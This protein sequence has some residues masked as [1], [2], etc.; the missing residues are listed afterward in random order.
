[1]MSN[2]SIGRKSRSFAIGVLACLSMFAMLMNTL[3]AQTAGAGT[4]KG[5][6][7]D[8]SQ[9][10]VAGATV[11]VTN[12]D[13]GIAHQYTSNESGLYVA[14]FLQP[15]HYA[16][17]ATSTGFGKVSATNLT[18]QVG[19]TMTIDLSL[20]VQSGSTT[21]E[22]S[23]ETP[24]LNVEQT[25][26]SQV[27]DQ[28]IIQNLPV[29]GRNWSDFVLLTPNVVQDG[30]SGLVSFHGISGLYNQNYV[31]GANNN[32]M[33]FSEARGRSSGAPFVYSL[34]AIKEF[35]A[36][37]SNY[38]AEFGQAAGGQVNAI[39][40]NGT[41]DMH[42]DLF[43]ALR[44]PSFNALDPVS[45][46]SALFN[47]GNPFLLTQPVHQQ[48]GFGGSIGGPI[49][50][51]KLFYFLTSDNFRRTGR[52]LY[53][54]TNTV[55]QTPTGAFTATNVISPNQC[56]TT[57][58]SAQ[59]TSGINF[60]LGLQSAPRRFAK[61]TLVFPR[62]DYQLNSKN[63]IYANFNFANF[64]Q[65]FGYAPNPTYSNTSASTNAPTSYHE[66]FLIAH[67]TSTITST[68]VNDLRFQWGRDLETAGANA[69][70]PSISMGAEIYGMPNALPRTAEPDEHRY[71]I[72][73]VFNKVF[74]RHMVKFGGD[75]NLVHEIMINLFQGGGIY[76]YSGNVTQE[77]QN[78]IVDAFAGQ[79]GNT[80]TYAG[81]HYNTFVQTIDQV[82]SVESGKAGA[83]DFWMK[84][85]D[86]FAEDTWKVSPK[87]TL[88]LGVRYDIQLTPDPAIPN[89]SSALA[90][91]YNTTI[92][93]V[94]DRVQPRLG[95]SWSPHPSTVLR[96][97]YG[98]FTGL[99]Q[100]STYYAMRVENGVY[101]INY[102][103]NG[104]NAT[105]TKPAAL[106]FP[107]VPFLPPGPPLSE[108]LYPNGGA[109][110]AV[111]GVNSTTSASFHGLSPDFVPPIT[112][113][114]D[115]ALEQAIPG[116]MSLSIGWVGTRALRL[117]VFLDANLVGQTPHGVRSFNITYPNGTTNLVTVPY[118]L[119]TD[120]IDPTLTSINAGFSVANSWYHGMAVTIRRP[121]DHGLELLVNYT[122]SKALDDDQVQGAFGTFY[123]GNPVLD[124]NNLRGEYGRSDIDMRGRFVGTLLYKPAIPFSSK[125][126]KQMVNGFTFSGTATESTGF[127][128][129]AS[130]NS[131]ASIIKSTPAAADG[132]IFGGTMSSSSGAPT[133]GR[134]PEIQRNSQPGP[135]VRNIDFRV[136]REVPVHERMHFEF[137]AE[138]FNLMNHTIISSV[139]TAFA[140]Q[141]A[142][143]GT[144]GACPTVA[145]EAGSQ[146]AGCIVPF[147]STTP[148]GAFGVMTTTNNALYG[149]RQLQLS[150]KFFF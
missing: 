93:N 22:V 143:T 139:N 33:L 80:D 75:V 35:Q 13:T 138:A 31:D 50:K 18:L 132:N 28:Q 9:A 41:N 145:V 118:Y 77:F 8:S 7:T 25:E 104:C 48:Q 11:T 26:V 21:V 67:W 69:S 110:P 119:A 79:P 112:H 120:R 90:A 125:I 117:P 38:S 27:V 6:V 141:L 47:H 113:E 76:G 137:I 19:Q 100:G 10:S 83:D 96:G 102:N 36:E 123:G 97:G 89:K 40:K 42:G 78:W 129:V 17:T 62:I 101:Q 84:M 57:I 5:T 140:T 73:D 81:S 106:Q 94:T 74:G 37:A 72:T 46:W 23:G 107:N 86:G 55:T 63:L 24:I 68:A 44:Y 60:L 105:C 127:P 4:I 53:Y 20:K 98:I 58:T 126:M 34:D 146:F 122:W 43:Y 149:P 3:H 134:P 128:I 88:N 99:N 114:M 116:K 147:V 51:D 148:S 54:E 45:K 49:K 12:V 144:T 39:T 124:P 29:N 133:T 30:G 150:G 66:R 15:G 95:F 85:Y 82:N 70:G 103:Y 56:P 91:K 92:K 136:T 130:M 135:G 59:C 2:L 64:D 1:M 32:Q 142:P 111:T 121:F 108:A 115:L 61:E 87:L 65:T 71:Q 109:A 16:V 131:P 14:P 52:A